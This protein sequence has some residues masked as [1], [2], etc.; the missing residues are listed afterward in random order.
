M[1]YIKHKTTTVNFISAL[2]STKNVWK[3]LQFLM[4][5][6]TMRLALYVRSHKKKINQRKY[7]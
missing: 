4:F 6:V 5:K 7:L 2:F 1:S 3:K